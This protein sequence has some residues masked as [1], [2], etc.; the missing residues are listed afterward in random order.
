M[1]RTFA[2]KPEYC[3]RYWRT[4]R[5]SP[6]RVNVIPVLERKLARI[7][8]LPGV[9]GVSAVNARLGDSR[10]AAALSP[11][12]RDFSVVVTS[13]PYYGMRTYVEDQWLRHWF[14]GGPAEITYGESDQI[15]HTGQ[16]VFA[17]SLGEVWRNMARTRA[18]RL[19]M[20]IR[21][22][23]IPSARVDARRLIAESLEA[24]EVE[25]RCVYTRAART[26]AHGRR[27][28]AQMSAG[29]T[30]AMEYDFHV[31]AA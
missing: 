11:D 19:D 5:L 22:G 16:Q 25:W 28:A 21:F 20:Y 3:I 9:R 31:I 13:P 6:P 10:S 24:S 8:A 30:P 23:I 7:F 14:L 2:A 15:S 12:M 29:S 4:H 26:A 27:Q 18:D 1:P 17:E